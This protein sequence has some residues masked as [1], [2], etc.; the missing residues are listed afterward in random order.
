MNKGYDLMRKCTIKDIKKCPSCNSSNIYRRS[1][2]IQIRRNK[3]RKD[4]K[5][6]IEERVKHYRCNICK[7]EF[8]NP[9]IEQIRYIQTR[10]E[11]IW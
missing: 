7:Y 8:D 2:I 5:N 1:R 11:N 4:N 9:I 10:E 3:K 6:F